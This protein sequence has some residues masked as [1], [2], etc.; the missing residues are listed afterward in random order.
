MFD[1][2]ARQSLKSGPKFIDHLATRGILSGIKV[3][4]GLVMMEG[5][6]G[7]TITQ[8]LDGLNARCE[9][10]YNMGMRFAKWRAVIKI[11]GDCPSDEAI[12][13][14]ARGLARYGRICQQ[15]GL[16]PIIEPE[17][18]QDGTHTIQKCAQVTE[19]VQ[20]AVA[21][22]M[23][24]YGLLMEGLVIK[25]NM[26]TPGADC[27]TPAT[28]EE[29]AYYTARTLNRSIPASVPGIVFLSGGQSEEHASQNFNAMNQIDV[30]NIPFTLTFS[31]GRALQTS[32]LDK[33]RG[34][35]DNVEEAQKILL[36][37]VAAN[38][39]AS[40]GKYEGGSGSTVSDFVANYV[41]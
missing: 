19:K 26:V 5:T 38:G 11:E 25:P 40:L 18:L 22:E 15:N 2:T 32:V 36:E 14:N 29:I 37:R 34:N 1:E 21:N 3:D 20:L 4:L 23:R 8:G 13:E 16:V 12:L 30:K 39:M 31:F 7:E 9:E 33:W 35:A 17:I 27:T 28:A 41:Y 6:D 10:Y 24:A